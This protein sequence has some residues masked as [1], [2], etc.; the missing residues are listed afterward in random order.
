MLFEKQKAFQLDL[1]KAIAA[2]LIK[3]FPYNA[4]G[5]D[6]WPDID[7][8]KYEIETY[9]QDEPEIREDFIKVESDETNPFEGKYSD[10]RP[11]GESNNE[12]QK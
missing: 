10:F 7:R 11:T 4:M 6:H 1:E 12:N 9:D 5:Q 8:V 2:I 3:H